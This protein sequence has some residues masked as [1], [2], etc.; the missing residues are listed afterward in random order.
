[1]LPRPICKVLMVEHEI[2]LVSDT[3]QAFAAN[4]YGDM[5]ALPSEQRKDALLKL[6]EAYSRQIAEKLLTEIRAALASKD[7]ARR[8]S[9]QLQLALQCQWLATLSESADA[10]RREFSYTPSN[11]HH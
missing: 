7:R 2:C 3:T 4:V 10:Y 1:M 8:P 5:D 9:T 6:E 11:I